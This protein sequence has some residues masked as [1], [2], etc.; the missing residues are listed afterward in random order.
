MNSGGGRFFHDHVT[1]PTPST[2]MSSWEESQDA[3]EMRRDREFPF[4]ELIVKPLALRLLSAPPVSS[5]EGLPVLTVT[6]ID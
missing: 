5:S 1:L 6:K 2:P 4:Q 3:L